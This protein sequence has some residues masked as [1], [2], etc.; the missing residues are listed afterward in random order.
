MITPAGPF[1]PAQT[2]TEPHGRLRGAGVVRLA[3]LHGAV[4]DVL[5]GPALPVLLLDVSDLLCQG[6][7]SQHLQ[8]KIFPFSV[9]AD[10]A[11]VDGLHVQER[12]I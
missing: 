9:W 7:I 10:I 8:E 1:S 12:K 5:G 11:V 4:R 2:S 3:D 6:D